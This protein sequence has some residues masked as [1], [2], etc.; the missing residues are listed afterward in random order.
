MDAFVRQ[1]Q[2][3]QTSTF[4]TQ[5]ASGALDW[6]K[7]IARAAK[8]PSGPSAKALILS[9]FTFDLWQPLLSN[10]RDLWWISWISGVSAARL[11]LEKEDFYWCFSFALLQNGQLFL[12]EFGW[13]CFFAADVI[14]G[15]G[16][17]GCP[18]EG[19][20]PGVEVDLGDR[21]RLWKS[22]LVATLMA[23]SGIPKPPG[24]VASAVV[25]FSIAIFRQYTLPSSLLTEWVT[26]SSLF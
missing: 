19:K 1:V 3:N 6:A 21:K 22:S 5:P 14:C 2:E 9:V 7:A 11:L 20:P 25:W 26:R 18:S 4:L 10:V 12:S 24:Q 13:R 15:K 8:A 17:T 23:M 16:H